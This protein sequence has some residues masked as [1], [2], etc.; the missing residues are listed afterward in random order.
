[1]TS[2]DLGHSGTLGQ[3][4]GSLQ[5]A[6]LTADNGYVTGP[7]TKWRIVGFYAIFA[8]LGAAAAALVV[9]LLATNDHPA[10]HI[11]VPAALG[12]LVGCALMLVPANVK[13]PSWAFT[14]GLAV[15]AFAGPFL[16]GSFGDGFLS[17]IAGAIVVLSPYLLVRR[18]RFAQ[19][20]IRRHS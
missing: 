16:H 2:P 15:T 4:S 17:F 5:D 20:A 6:D 9:G 7:V 13:A 10:T 19:H 11:A 14:V 3:V 8:C 18:D 1:L 12:L